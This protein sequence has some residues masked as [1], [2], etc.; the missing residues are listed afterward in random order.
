MIPWYSWDAQANVNINRLVSQAINNN[1]N[2]VLPVDE[3]Y[4]NPDFLEF[5]QKL[6][7]AL[8]EKNLGFLLKHIDENIKVSFGG[9]QGIEDFIKY[10]ELDKQ[11]QESKIWKT[12]EETMKLGGKFDKNNLNYFTAPY[13]FLSE[14]ISDPYSELIITGTN[15]RIRQQPSLQGRILGSLSYE[16]V[17]SMFEDNLPSTTINGET[18][19]W[20]KLKTQTGV[21]GYVYG[22]YVRSPIDYRVNFQKKGDSWKMVFFV[23]GD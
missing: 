19:P 13:T 12:L 22:K 11:P 8:D 16:I 18:Y 3:A 1:E 4:K 9:H 10:W 2:R 17:T 14:K 15:V 23:A 20:V 5:R 7:R 6:L 21:E